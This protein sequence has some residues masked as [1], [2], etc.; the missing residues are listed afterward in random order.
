MFNFFIVDAISPTSEL[1]VIAWSWR[2]SAAA[3]D[4]YVNAMDCSEWGV[5]VCNDFQ[6]AVMNSLLPHRAGMQVNDVCMVCEVR[7][8][9]WPG[10]CLCRWWMAGK[11]FPVRGR[12]SEYG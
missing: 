4:L 7:G 8:A 2:W 5:V 1:S 10:S 6:R 3:D 9:R 11:G 12:P